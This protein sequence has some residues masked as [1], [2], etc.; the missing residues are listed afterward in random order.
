VSNVCAAFGPAA[1]TMANALGRASVRRG[2]LCAAAPPM[3]AR[4]RTRVGT[5]FRGALGVGTFARRGGSIHASEYIYISIDVYVCV[6]RL[7]I[8]YSFMRICE[9]RSGLWMRAPVCDGDGSAVCARVGGLVL[10]ARP[11]P[12]TRNRASPCRSAATACGFG[13]QAFATAWAFNANIGAWNTASVTTL[14]SVCAASRP[15]GAHYGGRARPGFGAARPV[16]R[17]GTADACARACALV[18]ALA[19]AG[20]WVCIRPAGGEVRYMHPNIYI[21]IYRYVGAG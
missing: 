9:N 12:E 11:E 21:Y 15:S 1:R 20:P 4:V 14:G 7:H 5:R 13:A 3:R 18:L 6:T 19:C 16:V 8:H 2:R 17:G 10:R